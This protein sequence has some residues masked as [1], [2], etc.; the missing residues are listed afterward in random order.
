MNPGHP[1]HSRLYID[2]ATPAPRGLWTKMTFA[3]T[4]VL[5]KLKAAFL[6]EGRIKRKRHFSKLGGADG[7]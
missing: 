4:K 3:P 2:W 5:A 6:R 7:S 1:T